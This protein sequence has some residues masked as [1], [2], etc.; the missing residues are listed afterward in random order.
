MGLDSRSLGKTAPERR[1]MDAVP[2]KAKR[3]SL[4][5]DIGLLVLTCLKNLDPAKTVYSISST[6]MTVSIVIGTVIPWGIC[7]LGGIVTSPEQRMVTFL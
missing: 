5:L 1:N 4:G 7:S 6:V 2:H 3:T